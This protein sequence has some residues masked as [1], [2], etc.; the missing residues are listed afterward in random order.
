MI[1]AFSAWVEQTNLTDVL[2]LLALSLAA[3]ED[4]LLSMAL[5]D[6]VGLSIDPN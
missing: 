2:L 5:D 3:D 4:P 6:G 1:R